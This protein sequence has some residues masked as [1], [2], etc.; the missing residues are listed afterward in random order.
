M[1]KSKEKHDSVEFR[2]QMGN[3]LV[4]SQS[5]NSHDSVVAKQEVSFK[6]PIMVTVDNVGVIYMAD[7][8]TETSCI[9]HGDIR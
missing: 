7:N 3:N 6:L 2:G 4:F 9:K 8:V 1:I 5:G